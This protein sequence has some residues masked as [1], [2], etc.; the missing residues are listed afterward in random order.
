M[1]ELGSSASLKGDYVSSVIKPP[2][3]G[4]K[5]P[6]KCSSPQ[7]CSQCTA[8]TD[9]DFPSVPLAALTSS[10]P[11]LSSL[12]LSF[13][14]SLSLPS[15]PAHTGLEGSPSMDSTCPAVLCALRETSRPNPLR[16]IRLCPGSSCITH[17][18]VML[19]SYTSGQPWF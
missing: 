13:H 9:T 17:A 3:S 10:S 8:Y 6:T 2:G 11:P 7:Q 15:S 18:Q 12:C 19:A 1:R 5:T 14:V 16:Q 4:I